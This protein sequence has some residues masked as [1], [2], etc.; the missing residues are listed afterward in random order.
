MQNILVYLLT[1]DKGQIW[2]Y[3]L[4]VVYFKWWLCRPA[5]ETAT[6]QTSLVCDSVNL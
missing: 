1:K 3:T 6:D 4:Q 2:H 5:A